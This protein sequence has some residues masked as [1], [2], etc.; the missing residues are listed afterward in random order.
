MSVS[1]TG[2]EWDAYADMWHQTSDFSVQ[3]A[4][5]VAPLLTATTR[6][7]DFGA[8]VGEFAAA[9]AGKVAEVVCVEVSAEMA[10]RAK[11]RV[12]DAGN[13]SV[14]LAELTPDNIGEML[15]ANKQFDLIV[16]GSVLHCVPDPAAT[17]AMLTSVATPAG[18]IVHLVPIRSDPSKPR[19]P[20][21]GFTVD[22]FKALCDA[23]GMSSVAI[24]QDVHMDMGEH[25][26]SWMVA[27]GKKK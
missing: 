20:D 10:K 15:G 11:E 1:K 6:V 23:G 22:E 16:T 24:S 18:T 12:K 17:I 2:K 19:G 5:K 14:V 8:G 25:K 27:Q 9:I 7:L 13:V 21:D 3:T 4:N 26:M